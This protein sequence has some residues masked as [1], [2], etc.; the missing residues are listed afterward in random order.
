[1]SCDLRFGGTRGRVGGVE[2]PF[3]VNR[4]PVVYYSSSG[5]SVMMSSVRINEV[6]P[7]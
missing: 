2:S 5:F 6:F 1:M 7:L 4:S 3:G